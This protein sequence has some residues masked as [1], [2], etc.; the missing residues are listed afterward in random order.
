MPEDTLATYPQGHMIVACR[1]LVP[2]PS[3]LM[4][5]WAISTRV[6]KPVNDDAELLT[7]I[8]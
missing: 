4:T 2:F 5:M 1:L 7:P 8:D 6:N 3:G